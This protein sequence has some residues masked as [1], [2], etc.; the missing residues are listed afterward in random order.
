[1]KVL[2]VGGGYIGRSFAQYAA[3]KFEV[4]LVDS[5]GGWKTQP[6]EGYDSVLFAAGIAHRKESF[7]KK[8]LYFEINR[9]LA[10]Q[11]AEKAKHSGVKQFVY[12]SSMS[13]FGQAKEEI[14][15]ATQ[16]PTEHNTYYGHSKYEAEIALKNLENENFKIAI[17]RPPMVYGHNCPGKFATLVRLAK[18]MPII[19]DT[20]N[21]RSMIYIDNLCEFLCMKIFETASGEFN[22]QNGEYVNTAHLIK[23][24]RRLMGR[25][26]LIIPWPINCLGT[27]FKSLMYAPLHTEKYQKYNLED[28][29]KLSIHSLTA[30][31]T[32]GDNK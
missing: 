25:K 10:I 1:M 6:F 8:T 21:S 15:E 2:V 30:K 16:P 31:R 17:I 32:H 18:Y 11:V 23:L 27:A 9:D 24:V 4:E 12:L 26:T 19:P 13:V 5:Y 3:K 14:S 22:P 28:S 20:K 7:D 29:V